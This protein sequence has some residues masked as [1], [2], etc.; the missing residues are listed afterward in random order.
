MK[1][2][3]KAIIRHSPYLSAAPS[4]LVGTDKPSP[5]LFNCGT[6][7]SICCDGYSVNIFSDLPGGRS[8]LLSVWMC[9]GRWVGLGRDTSGW[10]WWLLGLLLV[11]MV[12]GGCGGESSPAGPPQTS[13]LL[14]EPVSTAI[15]DGGVAGGGPSGAGSEAVE[16]V[17]EPV[18]PVVEEEVVLV[19]EPVQPVVEEEVVLVE[20]PVQPVVEEEV[21]L[22]EEP[23]QPVVEEEVV[24]VEEPVQPVVEEEVV[25]VEEPVQ[26]VVEEVVPVEEPV[27]LETVEAIDSG[28][29]RFVSVGVGRA[30]ICVMRVF[31][32][33]FCW[34]WTGQLLDLDGVFVSVGV[35]HAACGVRSESSVE[36]WGIDNDGSLPPEGQF[37]AVDVNGYHACGHLVDGE[38][39]CWGSDPWLEPMPQAP[40]GV[41]VSVSAG[42]AHACGIRPDS[43]TECWGTDFYGETSPPPGELVSVSAGGFFFCGLRPDKSIVCWGN[44][45]NGKL[46]PPPGDFVYVGTGWNHACALGSDGTVVCWGNNAHG[47]ATPPQGVFTTISVGDARTC[48]IRAD[49]GIACWGKDSRVPEFIEAEEEP[50]VLDETGV[51]TD[52]RRSDVTIQEWFSP[53]V[54]EYW[55]HG[56]DEEALDLLDPESVRADKWARRVGR[57]YGGRQPNFYSFYW[58][59]DPE[60]NTDREVEALEGALNIIRSKMEPGNTIYHPIRYDLRWA[61]YPTEAN[62]TGYYP[63]GE[64]RILNARFDGRRWKA[65]TTVYTPGYSTDA[66]AGVAIPEGPPIRPITPF[67]EPRWPD[68]A[69]ALGRGCPPVEEIWSV[70]PIRLSPSNTIRVKDQCTLDA[71]HTALRYVWS[72]PSELRQR[73]IR[74]GHVLT[75]LL[76]RFDNQ[77]EINPYLAAVFGE[78]A[79]SRT[80]VKV[81]TMYWAGRWPGASM[82]YLE[83]QPVLA[84]RELT[85][86]ERQG[87]IRWYTARADRGESIS[88]RYLQGNITFDQVRFPWYR[89]LMV[90]TAD[91]TWRLSYRAFCYHVDFLIVA[92]QPQFLCPDDPTPHFPDSHLFDKNISSPKNPRYYT[93]PRENASHLPYYDGGT[94]R[95]NTEYVG[96]PPS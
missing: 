41:F 8:S 21:V 84:N 89:A 50:E 30:D 76:E 74:D 43:R 75:E 28:S 54:A 88:P 90:R 36:C 87:V 48:G 49:G 13:A 59:H 83:Y 61:E 73:A 42:W 60:G 72:S 51:T 39:E 7:L 64:V 18:Q 4:H 68:T 38:V 15:G 91:G 10:G 1:R 94:P 71:I 62:I 52:D 5:Y 85:D 37:T 46:W 19:E 40:E 93:D 53:V 86:E 17:E 81:R 69:E 70:T 58:F 47:Q 65:D 82:I 11:V 96:V 12:A 79:R 6:L 25:L 29:V 56:L 67:A 57:K 32:S 92:E 34:D 80:T 55:R 33:V 35:G 2:P 14:S 44:A 9:S 3:G 78:E 77:H 27:E 26:P 20:E 16:D 22:V 95:D 45:H 31:G 23:V 24:L 66:G 63:V